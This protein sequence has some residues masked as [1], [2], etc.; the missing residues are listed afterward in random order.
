M[1][2]TDQETIYD[3]LKNIDIPDGIH[4]MVLANCEV[5][6]FEMYNYYDD[7]I[8]DESP[9][10]GDNIPDSK[11]LI[12]KFHKNLVIKSNVLFTPQTRKKGM[13]IYCSGTIDN[14]GTISMTARGASAE[15]QDVLLYKNKYNSYEYVPKIGADGGKEYTAIQNEY[16][17][18]NNGLNGDGRQTGG[19]GSG[20]VNG[21][22]YSSG[23][24][25]I[26]RGGKGTSYSGGSGSGGIAM[27]YESSTT[28]N[29]EIPSDTGGK[30][31]NAVGTSDTREFMGGGIGNP[32]GTSIRFNPNAEGTGGLLIIYSNCIVN[33]GIIEAC[34][35]GS[36]K[37]TR[38]SSQ[39]WGA[40]GGSSGGGSINIFYTISYQNNG[41]IN[42]NGGIKGHQG[43]DGG[44][45]TVT[46]TEIDKHYL[47]K[48][49]GKYKYYEADKWN[50]IVDS[51]LNN[52]LILKKDLIQIPKKAWKQ[53]DG[54]VEI[55]LL[56]EQ[57]IQIDIDYKAALKTFIM[58]YNNDIDLHKV[59][60]INSITFDDI[61]DESSTL[62]R[63]ISVDSGKSYLYYNNGWHK[64][65]FRNE[66]P[67][68]Y[69]EDE[70]NKWLNIKDNI[71]IENIKHIGLDKTQLEVLTQ[72]Q[73]KE[74]FPKDNYNKKLRFM[75]LVSV[76]NIE[77]EIELHNVKINYIGYSGYVAE[78]N[79][80]QKQN[81]NHIIIIPHF[82]AKEIKINYTVESTNYIDKIYIKG[83]KIIYLGD[84]NM[85]VKYIANV[86]PENATNKEVEWSVENISGKA[87]IDNTGEL[88][89]K[90]EGTIKIK[91]TAKDGS[92]VYA[93]KEVTIVASIPVES[94]TIDGDEEVYL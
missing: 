34:G 6:D 41:V 62:K 38:T 81:L 30:G 69:N 24:A 60:F 5:I 71:D 88:T 11:M 51:E 64:Y 65:Y 19:G 27:M 80:T 22:S 55:S 66:L 9:I 86:L 43:S 13:T 83:K 36:N 56:S 32:N 75:T 58:F 10:L 93:E 68:D 67:K 7:I 14:S 82:D 57:K 26:A 52:Y 50:D 29:G 85:A 15:G 31:G 35:I 21:A 17:G 4:S 20:G 87:E 2:Y 12:L 74:I 61:L 94:I 77:S 8:F 72:E 48:N 84:D 76:G 91:A 70:L 28:W 54:V 46:V 78:T 90:G 23:T 1:K 37:G 39:P 44:N 33:N 25:K 45:G 79:Y 3:Y 16:H 92:G 18:G 49:K 89:P 59:K 40:T 42:A 53:L 47:I 63:L 73:W